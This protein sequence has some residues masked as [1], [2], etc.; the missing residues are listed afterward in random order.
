MTELDDRI[1]LW[2]ATREP[3]TTPE[4]LRASIARV[5]HDVREAPFARVTEVLIGW[6]P[7]FGPMGRTAAILLVLALLAGML[8]VI[9]LLASR[10]EPGPLTRNGLVAFVGDRTADDG[11]DGDIYLVNE[12]G[13][14]L[15]QLT[16]TEEPEYSPAFSPDGSRLAYLRGWCWFP[17]CKEPDFLRP[18]ATAHVVVVDVTNGRELFASE[19][20]VGYAWNLEWSPDG[21]S[22]VA[23]SGGSTSAV[24]VETGAWEDLTRGLDAPAAW[25]PNGRWLLVIKGDLFAIP[26]SE[27]GDAPIEDPTRVPGAL[28]LTDDAARESVAS[29]SPDST[30]VLFMKST[31]AFHTRVE[32]VDL[33]DGVSKIVADPGLSPAWSPDG[34]R[35][36]FLRGQ[37]SDTVWPGADPAGAEVWI[38]GA[39]GAN[40]R[41]L[42][43]SAT[44]PK[45]S[46]DGT[47]LYLFGQDGLIAVDASGNGQRIRFMPERFWPT[48]SEVEWSTGEQFDGAYGPLGGADWQAIR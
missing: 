33:A 4:R 17:A 24:D 36:A 10:P 38:V 13:L 5:P 2:L 26:A 42:A 6:G 39:D 28:R 14:G 3:G 32:V 37:R 20:P 7:A 1:N 8:A 22:I 34:A 47:L 12:D 30:S 19:V 40:P 18:E 44:P 21:R 9:A 45:W 31:G 15:R 35:V 16:D 41:H 25:S 23:Q 27:V 11:W 48:E 43:E 29:W 46:P